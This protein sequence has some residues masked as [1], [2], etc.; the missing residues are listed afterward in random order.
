MFHLTALLALASGS[1]VERHG[2]KWGQTCHDMQ[3]N[4][5]QRITTIRSTVDTMDADNLGRGARIRLTMQMYGVGRT[6]RRA[7]ECP[8]VQE[9]DS[10]SV[11]EAQGLVET[12]MAQN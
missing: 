8:W 12:L 3:A 6:L 1:R 11:T 9:N 4:F 7:R 5:Q 2:Q 10:G